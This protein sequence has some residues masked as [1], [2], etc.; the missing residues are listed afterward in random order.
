[1]NSCMLS[2]LSVGTTY[3]TF[4]E[5]KGKKIRISGSVCYFHHLSRLADELLVQM[6]YLILWWGDCANGLNFID[7]SITIKVKIGA[8]YVPLDLGLQIFSGKFLDGTMLTWSLVGCSKFCL[9]F[10]MIPVS[11]STSVI[12]LWSCVPTS[13]T[14]GSLAV[15]PFNWFLY[16]L[17]LTSIS[18]TSWWV[19]WHVSCP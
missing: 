3:W 1:M 9:C 7:Y 12:F 13:F 15:L 8:F 6:F 10:L 5:G 14:F 4:F 17:F 16:N 18:S 2:F 11:S 19:D